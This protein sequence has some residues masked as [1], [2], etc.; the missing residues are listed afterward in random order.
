[1]RRRLLLALLPLLFALLVALELPLAQTYAARLTQDLFIESIGD[2][3]RFADRAD[4]TMTSLA[5]YGP[6]AD[7]VLRART[8]RGRTVTIV[9]REREPI[10]PRVDPAADASDARRRDGARSSAGSPRGRRRR[11]RG[12]PSR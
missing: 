4:E 7:E 1:M 8:L 10:V 6:L 2:A 11:G 5:G 3:R 9:D 12:A